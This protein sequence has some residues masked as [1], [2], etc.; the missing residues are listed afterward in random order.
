L[1]AKV[2][3]EAGLASYLCQCWQRIW[4]CRFLL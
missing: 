4:S 3:S 2:F 1:K